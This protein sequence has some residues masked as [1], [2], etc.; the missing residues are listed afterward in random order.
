MVNQHWNIE[1]LP[2]FHHF[3]SG[4]WLQ[5]FIESPK[6]LRSFELTMAKDES[7][8]PIP[9]FFN[10]FRAVYIAVG[11]EGEEKL[12]FHDA[13]G[14]YQAYQKWDKLQCG[15]SKPG[16]S[17]VAKEA[18]DSKAAKCF[19]ELYYIGPL[20]IP[21]MHFCGSVDVGSMFKGKR[22]HGFNERTLSIKEAE[23]LKV[24]M[25]RKYDGFGHETIF[26]MCKEALGDLCHSMVP[27]WGEH[28]DSLSA[29]TKLLQTFCSREFS[30]VA[31]VP[32]LF[33]PCC[34]KQFC[35][36]ERVTVANMCLWHVNM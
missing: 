33:I 3:C 17:E 30:M 24:K 18:L 14:F 31:E 10:C 9:T 29:T 7:Y 6:G 8:L 32:V 27:D 5:P 26:L 11:V 13:V 12:L 16:E 21:A 23:D 22:F 2:T 4:S 20:N 34:G 36:L 19:Q 1:K 25:S 35:L 15:F 28:L